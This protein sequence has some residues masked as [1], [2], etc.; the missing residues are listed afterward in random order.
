MSDKVKLY[1]EAK[2]Y[3]KLFKIFRKKMK[4]CLG[5]LELFIQNHG[6]GKRLVHSFNET[7]KKKIFGVVENLIDA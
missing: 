1:C 2:N 5:R 3:V 6:F 7:L 4:R